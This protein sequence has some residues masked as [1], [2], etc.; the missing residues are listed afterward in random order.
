MASAGTSSDLP[1]V[2]LCKISCLISMQVRKPTKLAMGKK[3]KKKKACACI[4]ITYFTQSITTDHAPFL[5]LEPFDWSYL[6]TYDKMPVTFTKT[7]KM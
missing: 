3:K 7:G 4:K 1:E 6:Q 2:S 5:Y